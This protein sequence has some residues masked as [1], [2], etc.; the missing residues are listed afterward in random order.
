[1][2]LVNWIRLR[3]SQ[4]LKQF[5]YSFIFL[6][7]SKFLAKIKLFFEFM[8][9]QAA[10]AQAAQ[11]AQ[12]QKNGKASEGQQEANTESEA[13]QQAM[14][15]QQQYRNHRSEHLESLRVSFKTFMLRRN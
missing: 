11:Q 5:K 8:Q 3:T 9:Q 7:F 6:F 4:S 13:N 12:T 14:F 10:Q 1:M 2:I 15:Q